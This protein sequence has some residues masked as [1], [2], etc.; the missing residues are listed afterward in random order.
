MAHG[1]RGISVYHS[2]ETIVERPT[3][4]RS[5][6]RQL[7]KN[8]RQEVE[9]M[10]PETE[11]TLQSPFPNTLLLPVRLHLINAQKSSK[12]LHIVGTKHSK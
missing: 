9:R 1:F 3:G 10:W 12:Q 8:P 4:G 6:R 11:I 7:F 2:R 5:V